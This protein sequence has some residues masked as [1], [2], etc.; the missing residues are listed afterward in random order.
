MLRWPQP[1]QGH[2][3][4]DHTS[5]EHG[6]PDDPG[7]TGKRVRAGQ[8]G[9]WGISET[10]SERIEYWRDRFASDEYEGEGFGEAD[11]L[12]AIKVEFGSAPIVPCGDQSIVLAVDR[13]ELARVARKARFN[14][15]PC[16]NLHAIEKRWEEVVDAIIAHLRFRE[17]EEVRVVFDGP[18]GPASG[19]FVEVETPD[20]ASVSA[21]EWHERDDGLWELRISAAI[22][23]PESAQ[24][25]G[26]DSNEGA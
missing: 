20:G 5:H 8:Q 2:T 14:K 23:K 26:E 6:L 4:T 3:R 13:E 24:T 22:L 19:R 11:V 7:H 12:H 21:G 25:S 1:I 9:G 15:G 10:V 18:P 16:A 17:V